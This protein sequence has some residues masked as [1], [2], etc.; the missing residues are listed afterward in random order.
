MKRKHPYPT[1]ELT[2]GKANAAST[3]KPSFST[4][5]SPSTADTIVAATEQQKKKPKM[6][7]ATDEDP[8]S[9]AL[10]Y[11]G[12]TSTDSVS[13]ELQPNDWRVCQVKTRTFATNPTVTQCWRW[14][15]EDDD[16]VE[17]QVLELVPIKWFVFREPYNFHL[18]LGDIQ[19]VSFARGS[20]IV[21]VTH[22]EGR[23]G[24]DTN[25][26]GDVMAQFKRER[27]TRRF[28]DFL[29]RGKGVKIVEVP[30]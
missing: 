4:A 2:S 27:T 25:P 22:K 1:P 7:A 21:I 15:T 9:S 16:V 19:K 26:R 20:T 13:G 14:A 23:D 29:G 28:L 18:K 6:I 12:Y 17:H 30:K 24:K 3:G 8:A 11:D 10:D 5:G